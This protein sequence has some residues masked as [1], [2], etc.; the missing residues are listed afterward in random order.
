MKSDLHP[1]NIGY[2]FNLPYPSDYL[3]PDLAILPPNDHYPPYLVSCEAWQE[4]LDSFM[5]KHITGR[6]VPVILDLGN[7]NKIYIRS[8]YS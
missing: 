6:F 5:W 7:G 8:Q 2:I 3:P 4:P 1:G